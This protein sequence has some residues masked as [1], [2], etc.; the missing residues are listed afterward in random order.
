M[1]DGLNK[2]KRVT[3][4]WFQKRDLHIGDPSVDW[5]KKRLRQQLGRVVREIATFNGCQFSKLEVNLPFN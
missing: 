4:R 3:V 2:G 5:S 1:K